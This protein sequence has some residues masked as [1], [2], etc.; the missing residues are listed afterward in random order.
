[1]DSCMRLEPEDE[2]DVSRLDARLLSRRWVSLGSNDTAD[3]AYLLITFAFQ[4]DLLIMCHTPLNEKVHCLL[5]LRRLIT[6]T[7]LTSEPRGER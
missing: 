1:M 2:D 7:F 6:L 4:Y 3:R 5:L